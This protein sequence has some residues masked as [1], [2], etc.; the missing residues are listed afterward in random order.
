M[1]N[2]LPIWTRNIKD[3]SSEEYNK[4]YKTLNN[5]WEDPLAYIHFSIEGQ[6]EFTSILFIPRRVPLDMYEANKKS[7]KIKLYV[8]NELI[9]DECDALI[10]DYLGFIVGIVNSED[11][12]ID[13]TNESLID[14]KILRVIKKNITKKILQLF[15]TISTN[16]EDYKKFYEQFGKSIKFGI[17]EDSLS[18]VKLVELLRFNSSKSGEDMISLSDYVKRMENSGSGQN[19]IFYINGESIIQVSNSPLVE[20]LTKQGIEVL[21]LIDPIDENIMQTL[22]E[23]EGYSLLN[24][25]KDGKEG[26]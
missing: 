6:L 17:V 20:Q 23:Y 11:L 19:S 18:K 9:I 10:P 8:R 16:V 5:D 2:N 15:D 21:Y 24:C 3:I 25:E 22:M 14:S 12:P 7:K 1:D 13:S 26:K 4:F